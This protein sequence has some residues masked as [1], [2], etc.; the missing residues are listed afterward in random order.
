MIERRIKSECLA[1]M[2]VI[3]LNSILTSAAEDSTVDIDQ[4]LNS[5]V[6]NL[7]DKEMIDQND[8]QDNL[9]SLLLHKYLTYLP[10]TP[11][12]EIQGNVSN[13][14]SENEM[15]E[16]LSSP[17]PLDKEAS[18][19]EVADEAF[20]DKINASSIEYRSEDQTNNVS[21]QKRLKILY[22]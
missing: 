9:E 7:A 6:S 17:A 18:R 5:S 14:E 8:L 2:L 16:I 21:I 13:I 20:S 22:L 12:D 3:N 15:V 10:K 1:K 11:L 19:L 4:K